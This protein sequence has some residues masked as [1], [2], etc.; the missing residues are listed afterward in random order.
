MLG[1]FVLFSIILGITIG[2]T[3]GPILFVTINETLDKG[4]AKGGFP[5]LLGMLLVDLIII[6]P[7]TFITSAF[8][9]NNIVQFIMRVIGGLVLVILG[10]LILKTAIF[11]PKENILTTNNDSLGSS[12]DILPPRSLKSFFSEAGESFTKIIV[13]QMLNPIAYVFWI[14]VGVSQMLLIAD[15]YGSAFFFL[16]PICFWI[17]LLIVSLFWILLG[18][19]AKSF[20]SSKW[21]QRIQILCGLFLILFGV[22]QWFS[23]ES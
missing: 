10:L 7:L 15:I 16:F 11:N 2:L 14:T 23:L 13:V 20:M 17:G 8:F 4:V 1:E 18:A 3:P 9:Q 6:I 19:K 22:S 21:Y 12:E 5:V